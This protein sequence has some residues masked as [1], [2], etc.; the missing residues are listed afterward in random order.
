MAGQ[1]RNNT[2]SLLRQ[3]Q[4]GLDKIVYENLE[5]SYKDPFRQ[6]FRIVP[7]HKAFYEIQ[8][9][10]GVG[11]AGHKPEGE[12]NRNYDT[13]NQHWV[14]RVPLLSYEKSMRITWEAVEFNLY[15]DMLPKMSKELI[16]AHEIRKGTEA[17]N[18]LNNGT[19]VTVT[20]GDGLP[21]FSHSHTVQGGGTIDNLLAADF[22]EDLIEQMR[23][24]I[25][26]MK[27]DN[28][29][30]G[31]Y[32]PDTLVY[33]EDLIHEVCRV[34]ESP[35]RPGSAENDINSNKYLGDIKK[36]VMWKRLS[37]KHATFLTTDYNSDSGLVMVEH[38]PFRTKTWTEN[39]SWDSIISSI[40]NYKFLV[41]DTAR[42]IVGSFP[43]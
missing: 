22:D 39:N 27:N 17:A 8:K 30:I 43:G 19:D 11:P 20:Y 4:A 31:D 28:G 25:L 9:V 38:E 16:N 34:L 37:N 1:D 33:S 15:L 40:S 32:V 3:L 2:G 5:R 35:Y 42:S 21:L 13:I 14:F 36:K 24:L 10:A 29:D 12:P 26:K 6:I 23:L 7:H 18:I 41:E